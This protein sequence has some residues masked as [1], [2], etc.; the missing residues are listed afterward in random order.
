[1]QAYSSI[2]PV[3]SELLLDAGTIHITAPDMDRPSA[4]VEGYRQLGREDRTTLQRL[5]DELD[6]AVVVAAREVPPDVVTLDSQV[7]LVDPPA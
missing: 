5:E 7:L 1:M 4:L 6:R 3:R 2:A